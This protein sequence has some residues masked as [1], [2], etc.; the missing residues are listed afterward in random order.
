MFIGEV[1]VTYR[2]LTSGRSIPHSCQAPPGNRPVS[3]IGKTRRTPS[4][5]PP[6]S[7]AKMCFARSWKPSRR[8]VT[9][10]RRTRC[11]R[12]RSTRI[13]WFLPNPVWKK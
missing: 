3:Y 8:L 11:C 10:I 6:S 4:P 1:I 2:A 9:S 7:T 13:D 5:G 12:P